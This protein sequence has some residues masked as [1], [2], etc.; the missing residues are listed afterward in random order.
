MTDPPTITV[1]ITRSDVEALVQVFYTRL[2]MSDPYVGQSTVAFLRQVRS[3][4]DR[5]LGLLERLGGGGD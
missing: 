2:R 4:A 1:E 3:D 5:L